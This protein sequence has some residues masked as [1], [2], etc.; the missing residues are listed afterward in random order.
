ME[1]R[2][3]ID[4][5]PI[6]R[7]IDHPDPTPDTPAAASFEAV[8]YASGQPTDRAQDRADLQEDRRPGSPAL[9]RAFE[10]PD[11]AGVRPRPDTPPAGRIPEATDRAPR[12]DQ[13]GDRRL[14]RPDG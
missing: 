14:A 2:R 9:A 4:P 6:H 13:P 3:G 12:A 5:S 8:Y 1:G 11:P 7:P 10:S